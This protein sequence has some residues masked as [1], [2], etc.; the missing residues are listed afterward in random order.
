MFQL[1][2][3]RLKIRELAFGLRELRGVFIVF[4]AHEHLAGFY[5]VSFLDTNPGHTANHF[6]GHLDAVSGDDVARRI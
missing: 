2:Q 6:R 3:P 1:R 4:E 5:L